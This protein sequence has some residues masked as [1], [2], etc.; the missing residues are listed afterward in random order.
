[1]V[2]ISVI[3]PYKNEA[4][5][6]AECI[7]SLEHQSLPRESYEIIMVDNNSSDE[8]LR[9][10][11]EY[12]D[13]IS[14]QEER[15]GPYAC[16]NTAL[17]RA[18]GAII[19]FTDADCRVDR[20]WLENISASIEAGND[21]VLGKRSFPRESSLAMRCIANYENVRIQYI[22]D[23]QLRECWYAYTNNMACRAALFERHGH[24]NIDVRT[25]DTEFLHRIINKDPSIKVVF[26]QNVVVCHLEMLRMPKWVRKQFYY[27]YYNYLVLSTHPYR[28]LTFIERLRI[29]MRTLKKHH[30]LYEI[31]L[32]PPCL[33][34][35]NCTYRAG[36]FTRELIIMVQKL[37]GRS[38]T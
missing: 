28:V 4:R 38:T 3:V 27:A 17:A 36:L 7:E 25:G 31:I 14:L 19:A 32:L 18:Q 20:D 9:I 16:R 15:K 26:V 37:L 29:L 34:V 13:I 23:E 1:M 21:V 12:T 30:A 22:F 33:F 8:S 35:G 2:K 6:I 11:K 5:L 24:F 10:V